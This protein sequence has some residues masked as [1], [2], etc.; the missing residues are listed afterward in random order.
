MSANG[1][2]QPIKLVDF[3]QFELPLLSKAVVQH[4]VLKIGLVNGWIGPKSSR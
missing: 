3:E 1:R 2:K 4:R